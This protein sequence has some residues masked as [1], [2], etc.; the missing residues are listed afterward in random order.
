MNEFAHL[1]QAHREAQI[2]PHLLQ[3]SLQLATVPCGPL[4]ARHISPGR[5]LAA[6]LLDRAT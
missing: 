1:A 4:Y 6:L 3:L 5:E 2:E